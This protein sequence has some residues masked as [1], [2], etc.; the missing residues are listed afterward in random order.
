MIQYKQ[1]GLSSAQQ[2]KMKKQKGATK[3]AKYILL[4]EIKTKAKDAEW[5]MEQTD[6]NAAVKIFDSFETVKV[7][8]RK[9]VKRVLKKWDDNDYPQ[10]DEPCKVLLFPI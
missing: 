9:T 7:E 2:K 5:W 3:M 6:D 8:M 10:Y 1:G 4:T